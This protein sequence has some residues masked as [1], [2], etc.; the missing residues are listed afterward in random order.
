MHEHSDA[1]TQ[2]QEEISSIWIDIG[3]VKRCGGEDRNKML[4]SCRDG[5]GEREM[6]VF[7]QR[8]LRLMRSWRIRLKRD[9]S[10]QLCDMFLGFCSC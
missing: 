1:V 5:D 6:E 3:R 8:E 4:D 2:L 10:H 9:L 7:R